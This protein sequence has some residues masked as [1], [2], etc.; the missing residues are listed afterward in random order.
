MPGQPS[1]T[2][3]HPPLSSLTDSRPPDPGFRIQGGMD[4]GPWHDMGPYGPHGPGLAEQITGRH[5]SGAPRSPPLRCHRTS[6]G[7][8]QRRALVH[9]LCY[10]PLPC[11]STDFCYNTYPPLPRT[12]SGPRKI[13]CTHD[14]V[15]D[16]RWA[17]MTWLRCRVISLLLI[18][19]LI[20]LPVRFFSLLGCSRNSCMCEVSDCASSAFCFS[21][22]TSSHISYPLPH[23][24]H[25]DYHI[26]VPA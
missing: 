10:I 3:R 6:K 25:D 4:D 21:I 15:Y 11:T 13:G 2:A 22:V 7:P 19:L 1:S 8:S 12:G 20:F 24:P 26:P 17:L 18:E 14:S 23:L 9:F 5:F 16:P